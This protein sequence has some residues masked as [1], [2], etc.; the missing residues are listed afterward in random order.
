[1]WYTDPPAR[2]FVAFRGPFCGV[3]EGAAHYGAP[4]DGGGARG[5]LEP[6][7]DSDESRELVAEVLLLS[8]AILPI[9]K[10]LVR[11]Y[12][13][14]LPF[15]EGYGSLSDFARAHGLD[16]RMAHS[17]TSA[18]RLFLVRPDAERLFLEGRLPLEHASLLG[19]VVREEGGVPSDRKGPG[20]DL[21]WVDYACGV[22]TKEFRRAVR[23]R[24]EEIRQGERV[25]VL[26]IPVSDRTRDGF[27]RARVLLGRRTHFLPTE[28]QTLGILV[29]EF[30]DRH[31]PVRRDA[32]AAARA[33]VAGETA[34][35]GGD[36]G[37][38]GKTAPKNGKKPLRRLL[39]CGLVGD[40]IPEKFKREVRTRFFNRCAVESCTNEDHLEF[41]H[42]HP[43][44]LGGSN[45]P[46]NLLL[47]CGRHHEMFDGKRMFLVHT[48][49]RREEFRHRD[50]RHVGYLRAPPPA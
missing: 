29:D 30:L 18:G 42:K 39:R 24:R 3:G 44:A 5:P 46:W 50:G 49:G 32:R 1:M 43:R 48:L 10:R 37:A 9:A 12:D 35:E 14:G 28:G 16:V 13:S 4:P 17:L 2:G 11:L 15:A 40:Y 23:N 26:E 21:D 6:P 34:A 45:H 31:D 27:H 41:A 25:S 20:G 36:A 7:L 19:E 38:N 33:T 8:G 22:S 47:L